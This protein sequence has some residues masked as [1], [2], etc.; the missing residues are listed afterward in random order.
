MIFNE[1][2]EIFVAPTLNFLNLLLRLITRYNMFNHSYLTRTLTRGNF[3]SNQKHIWRMNIGEIQINLILF[4]YVV[5]I[6]IQFKR[7]Y[8]FPFSVHL[9]IV[10][11][12]T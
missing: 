5:I 1:I 6:K 4:A 2:L 3:G 11:D 12:L 8:Q 7:I 9:S 10:I